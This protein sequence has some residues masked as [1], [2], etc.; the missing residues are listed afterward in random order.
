MHGPTHTH[1]YIYIYI[2]Y[3]INYR[4][5]HV[6]QMKKYFLFPY[7]YLL[8]PRHARPLGEVRVEE[9]VGHP[10]H[11]GA[12]ARLLGVGRKPVVVFLGGVWVRVGLVKVEGGGRWLCFLGV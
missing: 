8:G 9:E 11:Q 7:L 1:I 12:G 6:H 5:T 2:I 3:N 10:V 4:Y